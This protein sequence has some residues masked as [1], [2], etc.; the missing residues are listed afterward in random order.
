M[1][2]ARRHPFP[3]VLACLA[4]LLSACAT[5]PPD[6]RQMHFPP[7]SVTEPEVE[8]VQLENGMV[9]YLLPDRELPL[10]GIHALIRTGTVYEPAARGHVARFAGALLRKGGAGDLGAEELDR[11][12][13]DSAIHLSSSVGGESASASVN[14]LTRT[15]PQALGHFADMLRRPR[16]EE[17]QL[18]IQKQAAIEALRR[19]NDRP[20]NIARRESA[21]L[22]YGADHP[23]AREASAA[24]IEAVT[25]ADL[26][27]FH[28]RYY[29]P[30]NI[31]L[32]ITGD[33]DRDEMIAAING[34]FGDWPKAQ[35]EL[36]TPVPVPEI[37]TRKVAFAHR[38]LDQ[39]SIRMTHVALTRK[40]PDFYALNL[41][42]RILGQ[43]FTSRL[44]QEI[45]TKRG[46]AYSAGSGLSAGARDLGSFVMATRTRSESAGEAMQA[47]LAELERM[48]TETVTEQEL[49]EAKDAFLNGFVFKSV[50]TGQLVNRRMNLDY[51]DMPRDEMAR[52]R[53]NTLAVTADDIL[54]VVRKHLHPDRLVIVA[55]GQREVLSEAMAPLGE[56]IEIPLEE[57][58]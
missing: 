45:R 31:M 47:M 54:R 17:D 24:E 55:V 35:V 26:Q 25:R 43:G 53:E 12:L 9:L 19:K 2:T 48:R 10:I 4:V 8:V 46:L 11:A 30:N 34:A 23:L 39:V 18:V 1:R 42:N 16:F 37:G 21:K 14:S 15:F 41:A 58:E 51:F 40:H 33:F 36:A 56:A 20:D 49:A 28:R 3:A 6:P 32:G 5:L 7:V 29:H 57:A 52:L 44:F 27:D 22:V 13:S 50:S 38:P